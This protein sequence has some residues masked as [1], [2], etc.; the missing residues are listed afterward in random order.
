MYN[1]LRVNA[2][3]C[4]YFQFLSK[5]NM[6]RSQQMKVNKHIDQETKDLEAYKSILLTGEFNFQNFAK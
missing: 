2:M 3:I 6:C 1:S 5:Y 4:S